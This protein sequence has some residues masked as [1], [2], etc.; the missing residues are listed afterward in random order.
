MGESAT[1]M[2]SK[3]ERKLFYAKQMPHFLQLFSLFCLRRYNKL[4]SVPESLSNCVLITEF[5]VENNALSYLPE[6]LLSSLTHLT[7]LTLSR[8]QFTSYPVGGSS[9]FC[10]VDVSIFLH[11]ST[12]FRAIIVDQ[13]FA[14]S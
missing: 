8:N 2:R 6:G 11:S 1:L 13:Q 14:I 9:Q 10:S 3:Q 4:Q 12:F 7:S 5:N